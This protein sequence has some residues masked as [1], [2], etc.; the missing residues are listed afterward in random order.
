MFKD[1][2]SHFQQ[3]YLPMFHIF[4]PLTV[5]FA[6]VCPHRWS[7]RHKPRGCSR[8]HVRP[9]SENIR[10]RSHGENGNPGAQEAQT[11][12]L[13]L[14]SELCGVCVCLRTQPG[15][16]LAKKKCLKTQNT[17]NKTTLMISVTGISSLCISS[18]FKINICIMFFL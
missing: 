9:I 8:K 1:C 2:L 13:V 4:W 16:D 15:V 12:L 5:Y 18:I 11:L 10:G 17:Q 14:R 3:M 7:Q 6:L